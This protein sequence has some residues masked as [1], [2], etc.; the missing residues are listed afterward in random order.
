MTFSYS[1]TDEKLL[2][3]TTIESNKTIGKE[4]KGKKR[5]IIIDI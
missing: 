1:C 5:N 3:F 4:R 2:P